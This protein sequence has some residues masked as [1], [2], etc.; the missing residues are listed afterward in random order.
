LDGTIRS[1]P[2]A[3]ESASI[4][5]GQQPDEPAL[6]LAGSR[7]GCVLLSW[8]EKKVCVWDLSAKT[9]VREMP[10]GATFAFISTNSTSFYCDVRSGIAERDMVTGELLRVVA[11]D[12]MM[13]AA[14]LS[15]D[16]C[17]LA[18]ITHNGRLRM[19][20]LKSGLAVWCTSVAGDLAV[21]KTLNPLVSSVLAF[22]RD[23]NRLLSAHQLEAAWGVSIWNA[24]TGDVEKSFHAHTTC[25]AGAGFSNVDVL[26]T[27]ADRSLKKWDLTSSDKGVLIGE[28]NTVNWKM[29][30]E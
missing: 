23:G 10:F 26:Y 9:L 16:G 29:P 15:P 1:I 8:C 3:E 21:S 5:I 4:V 2:L 30:H 7:D 28:W 24:T 20:D 22:S 12:G 6:G 27:A 14:A 18:S 11:D 19:T 13:R 17:Q 25:I